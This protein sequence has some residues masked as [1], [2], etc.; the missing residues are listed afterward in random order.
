MPTGIAGIR[1][2]KGRLNHRPGAPNGNQTPPVVLLDGRL[3]FVH[4][5]P[6]AEPKAYVMTAPPPVYFSPVD[7][8]KN[9]PA[10][11]IR[12]VGAELDRAG[13]PQGPPFQPP[14]P[15]PNKPPTEPFIS[16]NR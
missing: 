16:P 12:D 14:G 4:T 3:V 5:A 8:V 7:G 10:D 11:L 2:T 1:G 13:K 15:P 9:A 6:G